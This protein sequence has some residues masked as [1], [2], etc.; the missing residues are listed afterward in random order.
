MALSAA[1]TKQYT[2]ADSAAEIILN[3]INLR[4]C[5]SLSASA[6]HTEDI[7]AGAWRA[8]ATPLSELPTSLPLRQSEVLTV[9]AHHLRVMQRPGRM[10]TV[11]SASTTVAFEEAPCSGSPGQLAVALPGAHTGTGVRKYRRA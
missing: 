1:T 4:H 3:M 8:P 7:H 9:P 2:H 11:A 10:L 5:A 6:H